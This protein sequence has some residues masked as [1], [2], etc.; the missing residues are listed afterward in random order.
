MASRYGGITGSK[1]I[2]EDFQNINI[3]FENVE[4]EMDQNKSVVDNHLTS[5][6]AHNADS[7][8]YSGE[9][10]GSN[11][12]QAI[13]GLDSRIDNLILAPGDSGPEV[14]DARGG[15]PVLGARLDAI[16]EELEQ[17]ATKEHYLITDFGAVPDGVTDSA[18]AI[19]AAIDTCFATGGGTVKIP[20]GN[21]Y[22]ASTLVI[23]TGVRLEGSGY[24]NW[25]FRFSKG[26][27]LIAD[28]S[29]PSII[30]VG[31]DSTGMVFGASVA[32]LSITVSG[33]TNGKAVSGIGI[34][35]RYS[36]YFH[37]DNIYVEGFAT[38]VKIGDAEKTLNH[39]YNNTNISDCDVFI[40]INNGADVTFNG[41]RIG[42]N[43]QAAARTAGIIIKGTCD[44]LAFDR[45]IIAHNAGLKY[46][47]RVTEV[48]ES[49]FWITLNDCDMETATVASFQCDTD[50][51]M[52]RINNSWIGSPA[53]MVLSDGDRI[54]V[55][56]CTFGNQ[57]SLPSALH[58]TGEV[59]N[60]TIEQNEFL[61]T[62][63]IQ[64]RVDTKGN[65][66]KIRDNLIESGGVGVRFSPTA[67][68]PKNWSILEND[69]K[70]QVD[71]AIVLD[72]SVLKRVKINSNFIT[73]YVNHGIIASGSGNVSLDIQGNTI[74]TIAASGT[75]R[76]IFIVD[77]ISGVI[78]SN[79]DLQSNVLGMVDNSV[80]PKLVANNL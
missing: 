27:W 24:V 37:S 80:V 20:A 75:R 46:N 41:G 21:F 56:D 6:T 54:T 49:L 72:L 68:S 22:C 65:G 5:K 39:Y 52:I 78:I 48:G 10:A 51:A 40:E 71:N 30:D 57:S 34:W 76:S 47:V 63:N 25:D 28:A 70:N 14:E 74:G 15:Y 32:N 50:A 77:P 53:P 7:I 42:T 44:S 16:D 4:K 59:G 1:R 55:R 79:N 2:S 26:T 13:D 69:I 61:S 33:Y 17:K 23:K 19:Q 62:P 31:D 29:L 35:E 58:I 67:G 60:V 36:W 12:K 64:V 43:G 66:I 9:A 38:G 73:D 45:L 18:P 8:T 3:A 11:V